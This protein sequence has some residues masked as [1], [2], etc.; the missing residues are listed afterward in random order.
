MPACR[1]RV[2][3]FQQ[4][5]AIAAEETDE[6]KQHDTGIKIGRAKRSR[7]QQDGTAQ[8]FL[9]RE[10]L[11]DQCQYQG[12]GQRE[13]HAGQEVG[14]GVRQAN[15][16]DILPARQLQH[17]GNIPQPRFDGGKALPVAS[18]VG[19][20]DPNMITP[21]TMLGPS[22]TSVMAI[23]ITAEVGR[24]RTKSSVGLK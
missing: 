6:A 16:G 4:K 8:A 22:P 20:I 1:Q 10:H 14:D 13:T 21:S 19:Q 5:Q 18:N 17:P 24:E 3:Q 23:G 9:A 2:A 15:L 12:H 11:A 7:C